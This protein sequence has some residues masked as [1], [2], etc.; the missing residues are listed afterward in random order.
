[1][2]FSTSTLFESIICSGTI[3]DIKFG[4]NLSLELENCGRSVTF[5]GTIWDEFNDQHWHQSKKPT[6]LSFFCDIKCT[7]G[8]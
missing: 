8:Q 6:K 1:M 5:I 7:V 4:A 2:N 3:L